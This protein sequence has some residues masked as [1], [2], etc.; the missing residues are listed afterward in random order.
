MLLIAGSL[1][2]QYDPT[3]EDTPYFEV[4]HEY[5]LSSAAATLSIEV[6]A[7]N[8]RRVFLSDVTVWCTVAAKV[9]QTI[10]ATIGSGS[11]AT[12]VALNIH[13]ASP[14]VTVKYGGSITGGTAAAP[15]FTLTAAQQFSVSGNKM[16]F[17]VGGAASSYAINT[18]AISGTCRVGIIFGERRN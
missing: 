14:T 4:H 7:S 6:P 18:D 9:T 17:P 8:T 15:D 2:A 1:G 5:S 16:V 3:T 12:P 13:S 10:G 11:A